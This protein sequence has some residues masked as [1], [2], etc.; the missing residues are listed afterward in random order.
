MYVI[1]ILLFGVL[2]FGDELLYIIGKFYDIFEEIVG[3]WGSGVGFL[4]E[5]NISYKLVDLIV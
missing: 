2:C 1:G 4:K 3:I 5:Y